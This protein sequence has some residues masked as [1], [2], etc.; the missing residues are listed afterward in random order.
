MFSVYARAKLEPDALERLPS[1]ASLIVDRHDEQTLIDPGPRRAEQ[2]RLRAV[3]LPTI[4]HRTE[5]TV[6]P[7]PAGDAVKLLIR[8]SLEEGVGIV[9][10]A[11]GAMTQ[12]REG[13]PVP[14]PR[15]RYRPR[16]RGPYH[17]ERAGRPWL[18]TP[19]PS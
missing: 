7:L 18:L 12:A 8:S 17:P 9:D 2:A 16:R 10:G 1:L 19:S 6:T 3:L 5:T 4:T 13:R 15:P 11:L 14:A